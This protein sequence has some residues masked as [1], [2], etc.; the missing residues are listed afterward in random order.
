MSDEDYGSISADNLGEKGRYRGTLRYDEE[1]ESFYFNQSGMLS[2]KVKDL[3]RTDY[4]ESF[5]NLEKDI[6]EGVE[7]EIDGELGLCDDEPLSFSLCNVS[8]IK[9]LSEE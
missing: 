1:D 2:A 5:K 9:V 8:I 6:T 7:V 4:E 3:N